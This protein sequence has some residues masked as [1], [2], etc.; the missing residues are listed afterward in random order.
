[1]RDHLSNKKNL[2]LK[3]QLFV[4]RCY[5]HILNAAAQDVIAS[6][7]GVVYNI[8]ESIKFIKVSFA[9]EEK[10]VEIAG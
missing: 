6:I 7:H 9:G 4:V 10:F 1:M 8:S 3:G 2:M 5:A